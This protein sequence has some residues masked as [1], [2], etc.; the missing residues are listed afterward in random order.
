ME[1]REEIEVATAPAK[2]GDRMKS[3]R[4]WIGRGREEEEEDDDP[5]EVLVFDCLF[6]D[7]GSCVDDDIIVIYLLID[8]FLLLIIYFSI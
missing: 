1:G 2:I 8:F 7:F 3:K 4:I 5:P 6:G